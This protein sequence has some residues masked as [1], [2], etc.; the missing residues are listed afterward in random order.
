LDLQRFVGAEAGPPFAARDAVN[1]AMI[2]H[3]CD[4][5][6]DRNPVYTD[7]EAAATSVHG[8]IVAPP[9]MLQAWTM[10][11]LNPPGGEREGAQAEL[12]KT[13]HEAG[14]TSVVATNCEQEYMRYLRPGDELTAVQTYESISDEKHTALG[15]GFFVTTVTTFKDQHDDVVGT[16]RFR[17]LLYKPP[18][19]A[20]PTLPR[21]RP[22][23]NRDNAYFWE[24]VDRGE[25]LIQRCTSCRQLRHPP[26]PACANCGALEWDTVPSSGRGTVYSWVVPHY[27][28]VPMFDYPYIVVLVELE[29]GVRLVSNLID[30]DPDDVKIGMPVE[31]T[32]VQTDPELTLPMFRPV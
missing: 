24:G 30:I 13:V 7:P 2:R 12:M 4:A 8:G 1:Q 27:P 21:P 5:I 22:A 32:Y 17:I 3:W 31:V 25:L 23:I 28:V 11:G 10:R 20:E 15:D 19:K 14:Y 26:M 29:E 9:T 16:M 6:G 18:A